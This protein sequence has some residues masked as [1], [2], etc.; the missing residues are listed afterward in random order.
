MSL[1]LYLY[2]ALAIILGAGSLYFASKSKEYVKFLAGAFFVS[3]GMLLY[4]YF[5]KMHV[6]LLGTNFVETPDISLGRGMIHFLLF[7]ACLYYG[8]LKKEKVE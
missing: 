1:I 2:I 4:F 7:L 3:S 6:P 8:F 5:A